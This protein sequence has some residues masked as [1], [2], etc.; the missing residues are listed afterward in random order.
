MNTMRF[1]VGALLV[2]VLAACDDTGE[3]YSRT[4]CGVLRI[5]R[6][7]IGVTIP[8]LNGSVDDGDFPLAVRACVGDACF[9]AEVA[10]D[11]REDEVCLGD[12]DCWDRANEELTLVLPVPAEGLFEGAVHQVSVTITSATGDT[13]VFDSA[14]VVLSGSQPQNP[15]C[16]P[17]CFSGHVDL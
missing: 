11:S 7:G 6:S 8:G 10:I 9:D 13:L 1:G 14:T 17:K 15:G 3:R 12:V 16:E 5:C 2:A 4:S